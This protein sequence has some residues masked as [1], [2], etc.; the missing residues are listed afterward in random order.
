M[1]LKAVSFIVFVNFKVFCV[2]KKYK[3]MCMLSSST[4]VPCSIKVSHERNGKRVAHYFCAF[5]Q[6]MIIVEQY[7][8]HISGELFPDF[9][10]ENF[11]E[12]FLIGTNPKVKHFCKM[13]ILL[14]KVKNPK[15]LLRKLAQGNVQCQLAGQI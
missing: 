4:Y 15:M 1:A 2:L 14:K 9:V 13:G 10:R 11:K 6:G 8:G 5:T 12:V 3:H 7:F